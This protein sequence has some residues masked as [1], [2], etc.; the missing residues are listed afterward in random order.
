MDRKK[1]QRKATTDAYGAWTITLSGIIVLIGLLLA[2]R[3][4]YIRKKLDKLN[5][6]NRSLLSGIVDQRE[7]QI[8]DPIDEILNGIPKARQEKLEKI[9]KNWDKRLTNIGEKSG[10]E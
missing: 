4:K 10:G 5:K 1:T 2:W 6:I 8:Y 7:G 3:A 9:R